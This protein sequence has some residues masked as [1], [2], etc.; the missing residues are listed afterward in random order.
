M[1]K[2]F[3]LIELLL[4][5]AIIGIMA[6]V[7]VSS[8]GVGQGA[9]RIRGAS[10]DIFAAIRQA[11]STA[12]VTQQPCIISYSTVKLDGET[13]A[14][15]EIDG[16]K[17]FGKTSVTTAETI[18]GETV[19]LGAESSEGSEGGETIEEI[20]FAPISDEV[21]RGIAIKVVMQGESLDAT[22]TVEEK[23]KSMI[24]SYSNVDALLGR[25]RER[26]KGSGD[27]S[28][29]AGDSDQGSGDSSQ[30]AGDDMQEKVSVVWET[31]GRTT[32]HKVYV[33]MAGKRPDSGLVIS[34]DMFGGMKVVKSGEED[35]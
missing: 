13:C 26:E 20:L 31:N 21:V 33:Y 35:D 10:R 18:S 22:D 32:A 9:A 15:V 1:R 19:N 28:Q 16:A 7:A 6:T 30:E 25:Y 27:S 23:K 3:T 14:K 24:S 12:L 4:I 17:L 34:V 29:G 11:R 5:V 2:A 8:I